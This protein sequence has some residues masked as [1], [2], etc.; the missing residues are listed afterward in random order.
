ML[1]VLGIIFKSH[2]R[3]VVCVCVCVVFCFLLVAEGL[4]VSV[5]LCLL[6]ERT[7]WLRMRLRPQAA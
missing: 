3:G 7:A 4:G 6:P 1:P 5:E 2:K